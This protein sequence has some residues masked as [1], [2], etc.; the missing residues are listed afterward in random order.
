MRHFSSDWAIVLI[1]NRLLMSMVTW[2]VI[3]VVVGLKF[4]FS[5]FVSLGLI[6]ISTGHDGLWCILFFK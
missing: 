2:S 3:C 1:I 4:L 5:S 6:I